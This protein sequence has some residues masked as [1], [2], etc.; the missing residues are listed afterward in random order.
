MV[1]SNGHLPI[2]NIELNII[3]IAIKSCQPHRLSPGHYS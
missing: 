3:Q 2:K 1:R